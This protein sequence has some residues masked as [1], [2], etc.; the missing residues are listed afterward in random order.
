MQTCIQ[1]YRERRKLDEKRANIFTKYLVLGGIEAN[2]AKQ[3]TGGLD[4]DTIENSTAEE[5]AA[6][7]ATDYIRSNTNSLR[8]YDPGNAKHWVVDFEGLVKGFL[9]VHGCYV[10]AILTPPGLAIFLA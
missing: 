1:R 4:Q 6:I 3:F 10:F 7:R 5:I 8:F 2:N 9:Y